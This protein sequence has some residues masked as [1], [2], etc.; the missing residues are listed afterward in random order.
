[1]FERSEYLIYIVLMLLQSIITE[2]LPSV[3]QSIQ[4]IRQLTRVSADT[5]LSQR[6]AL[7][8]YSTV[9][10]RGAV[11]LNQSQMQGTPELPELWGEE[12]L[13]HEIK[14]YQPD[15]LIEYGE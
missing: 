3:G 1:M 10:G 5:F 2:Y 6:K 13:P 7:T 9:C 14:A 15:T 8:G 4:F 11:P 12:E